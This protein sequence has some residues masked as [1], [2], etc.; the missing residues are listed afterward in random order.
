[1]NKFL[2]TRSELFFYENLIFFM[3]IFTRYFFFVV[4]YNFPSRAVTSAIIFHI[5]PNL[6]INEFYKKYNSQNII[7]KRLINFQKKNFMK[8]DSKKQISLTLKSHLLGSIIVY[9]RRIYSITLYNKE[10]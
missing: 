1:M 10:K 8:I 9:M 2:V 6:K 7:K 5:K 4:L 3:I